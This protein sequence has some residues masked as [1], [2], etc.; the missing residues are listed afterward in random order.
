MTEPPT[1][2]ASHAATLAWLAVARARLRG[3]VTRTGVPAVLA[4]GLITVLALLL[5]LGAVG[6]GSVSRWA[7]WAALTGLMFEATRRW[8]VTPWRATR[9]DANVARA[10]EAVA[11]EFKDSLRA[12]VQLA[13]EVGRGASSQDPELVEDQL[14]IQ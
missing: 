6:G 11:P 14:K 2:P 3:R 7:A 5:L 4:A 1:P 13:P 10:V 8:L 12:V 9:S